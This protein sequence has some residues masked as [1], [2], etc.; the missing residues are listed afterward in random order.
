MSDRRTAARRRTAIATTLSVAGHAVVVLMI[1]LDLDRGSEEPA[2]APTVE[3]TLTSL[4]ER[5][6][7][8]RPRSSPSKPQPPAAPPR[9]RRVV[10][11]GVL[12][13][14]PVVPYYAPAAPTSAAPSEAA[15]Q[16]LPT[17]LRTGCVGRRGLAT[18]ARVDCKL[19]IWSVLDRSPPKALPGNAIPDDKE[20]DWERVAR[21]QDYRRRGL[22]PGGNASTIGCPQGNLGAGCLDEMLIP[23]TGAAARNRRELPP[24]GGP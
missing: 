12:P 16:D 21:R 19:E 14:A 6:D 4:E 22:R 18:E 17:A 20:S 5:P 3:V 13:S 9:P 1:A 24:S 8:P 15:G 11:A 10:P 2:F 7:R 23:M